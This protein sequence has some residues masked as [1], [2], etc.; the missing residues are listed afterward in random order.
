MNKAKTNY[1]K[2]LDEIIA[3]HQALN[4]VPSLLLHTCCAPC[5]SYTLEYLSQHFS[6]TVY[7]YNPNISP[8]AEYQLRV[9]EQK[10]LISQL[11]AKHPISFIEGEYEP[12]DFFNIAKG[13]ENEPEGGERCSA[14]FR[15]RLAH[16]AAIAAEM[17]FDYFTTSLTISPLKNA[18]KI[19]EIGAELAQIHATSFLPSDFKKRGGYL[20]SIQLSRQYNLYRQ[21]FCG[22]PFSRQNS[23]S[24]SGSNPD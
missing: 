7:F 17:N 11:P 1:Q 23:D 21:N 20:R 12:K 22:C 15:L 3:R 19:N 16:T 6:V 8:A 24:N 5:S 18:D 14:C 2:Q 9:Q 4:E 10:R 13:L